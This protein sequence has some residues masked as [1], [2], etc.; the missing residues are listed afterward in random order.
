[1]ETLEA[2]ILAPDQ[3]QVIY[4]TVLDGQPAIIKYF[5]PESSRAAS[6][7]LSDLD[8]AERLSHPNLIRILQS[9]ETVLGEKPM[10]YAI[11]E[12]ADDNL[13]AVLRKRT[14]D[15]GEMREVLDGILPALEFLHSRGFAHSRIRPSNILACGDTVKLSSDSLRAIAARP[16][17]VE[18]P[19]LYDA[20]EAR[21][22]QFTSACDV[23]SVAV[24]VLE[25][26][27]GSPLESG[28]E[29]LSSPFREIVAGGLKRDAER[30][31]TLYRIREAL[32]PETA[33][34]VPFASAESYAEKEPRPKYRKIGGMAIAGAIVAGSVCALLVRSAR[35]APEPPATPAPMVKSVNKPAPPV[36]RPAPEEPPAN[37]P[38]VAAPVPVV[39]APVHGYWAVVGA[40]YRR[41]GDAEKR[42]REFREKNSQLKAVVYPAYEGARRY[43]VLFGNGMSH[44]EAKSEAAAVRRAGGPHNVYITQ[45][46]TTLQ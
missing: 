4:D 38:V 25:A 36:A 16:A 18:P 10:V 46:L 19:G 17:V 23:Y 45:L 22:G 35:E 24:L 31:W 42:A 9:G 1:M 43:L 41:Q 21:A 5:R 2:P 13:A 14:L 39:A 34:P 26:L 6:E 33:R 3:S 27:T 20:P 40:A 29:R 15:P 7:L 8:A 37:P 11:M 28:V 30:R 44:K 32:H 12:K